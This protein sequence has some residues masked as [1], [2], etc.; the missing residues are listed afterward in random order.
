MLSS[1]Y[2]FQTSTLSKKLMNSIVCHTLS[3]DYLSE[4]LYY[5]FKLAKIS[6]N[7]PVLPGGKAC[8]LG[9]GLGGVL[10]GR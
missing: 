9:S 4:D 6:A 3:T 1:N 5:F 8:G 2:Y 10:V 7:V